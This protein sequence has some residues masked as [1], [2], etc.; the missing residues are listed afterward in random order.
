MSRKR[1][2]DGAVAAV[3]AL[4]ALVVALPFRAEALHLTPLVSLGWDAALHA[5]EG[6]DLFDDM[7]LGRP[8][9]AFS[10]LVSRHWWGPAWALVSAPFQAAFGPSLAAASL[11]SLVAF[12]LAPAVA[13]L[14]ARRL[15]P[16]MGPV[17]AVLTGLVVAGFFLR[18]PMLL[19]I[20]AWPMLESL[21]GLVA[22]VA[23]LFFARREEPGARR[24]AFLAGTLLFL[25][26]HHFG[27]FVLA[28]LG[29]VV[30]R[31]ESPGSKR[32]LAAAA[33]ALLLRGAGSGILAL[34]FLLS[35]VRFVLEARG[36]RL[37]AETRKKA[38]ELEIGRVDLL[39]VVVAVAAVAAARV[40]DERLHASETES[41]RVVQAPRVD[42]RPEESADRV[43]G[44]VFPREAVLREAVSGLNEKPRHDRHAEGEAAGLGGR[45]AERP[46]DALKRE[47]RNVAEEDVRR[48][49]G[50][51]G[52]C[53]PLGPALVRELEARAA[54]RTPPG[55]IAD[56]GRAE[57]DARRHDLRLRVEES[58]R[59][60][61]G[62]RRRRADRRP[63]RR[64]LLREVKAR[65]RR[66]RV[67]R[68]L[69][70]EEARVGGAREGCEE[71]GGAGRPAGLRPHPARPRVRA[72]ARVFSRASETFFS[73][74]SASP[75]KLRESSGSDTPGRLIRTFASAPSAAP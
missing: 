16:A 12:V 9:D 38:A 8:L 71:E 61:G 55:E 20:S 58:R 60:Q 45:L 57:D 33:R 28:T 68:P 53:V 66:K 27:F 10:L 7:R 3:L 21:G 65:G 11:P 29:F 2:V 47:R 54:R 59:R 40:G 34:A 39:R 75:R 5:T 4:L 50:A 35:A 56:H 32:R 36:P 30:W 1:V 41:H 70:A 24:M 22:L 62:R 14:L 46:V 15:V 63:G 19:E 64:R 67:A 43:R 44:L 69:E 49:V 17:S 13:F 25:L 42:P 37:E 18:S 72:S 48:L 6:L 73:R 23:F 74:S 26:K 31:E 51:A 52:I